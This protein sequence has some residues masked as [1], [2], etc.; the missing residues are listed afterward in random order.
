MD[1]GRAP[2]RPQG[3]GGEY[4]LIQRGEATQIDQSITGPLGTIPRGL[5]SSDG[6]K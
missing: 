4:G 1:D 2:N 5:R 6:E 3:A